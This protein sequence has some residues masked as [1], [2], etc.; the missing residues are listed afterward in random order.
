MTRAVAVAVATT[1]SSESV[2]D[3]SR[4]ARSASRRT[5]RPLPMG[6]P[7]PHRWY[8][9]HVQLRGR[10]ELARLKGRQL[11]W[12]DS[13]VAGERLPITRFRVCGGTARPQASED[14]I[15]DSHWHHDAEHAVIWH[16]PEAVRRIE[17][18]E[19]GR[20]IRNRTERGAG[21]TAGARPLP[22]DRSQPVTG[23]AEVLQVGKPP[24]RRSSLAYR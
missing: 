4:N 15:D 12:A 7:G 9:G 24:W 23:E 22:P 1:C 10:L 3:A 16:R 11:G 19:P 14:Q 6:R 20:P 21:H 2:N 5:M 13:V 8:E 18:R 17:P